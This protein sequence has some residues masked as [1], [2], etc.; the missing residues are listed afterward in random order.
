MACILSLFAV[1]LTLLTTRV[2]FF[3]SGALMS[4]TLQCY[5]FHKIS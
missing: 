5:V 2:V 1:H 3:M 4:P